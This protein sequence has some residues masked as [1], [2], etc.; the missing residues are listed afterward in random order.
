MKRALLI[1]AALA[2]LAGGAAAVY[3]LGPESMGGPTRVSLGDVPLA[4][5]DTVAL[6]RRIVTASVTGRVVDE[7][8][9]QEVLVRDGSGTFAVRFDDGE[10]G[11]RTGE[12]LLAVGRVRAPREGARWLDAAGWSRVEG[13]VIGNQAGRDSVRLEADS[14]AV[15]ALAVRDSA[16]LASE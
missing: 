5:L 15:R 1:L 14:S 11:V 12:T 2:V 4:Q 8:S 3:F 6:R 13:A 10:H 7:P 9:D 16:R